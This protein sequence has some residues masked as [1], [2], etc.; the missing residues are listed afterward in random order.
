[1]K[2]KEKM[3]TCKP[4]TEASEE[5]KPANTKKKKKKKEQEIYLISRGLKKPF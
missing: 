2:T 1:M 4:R 3:A 5:V